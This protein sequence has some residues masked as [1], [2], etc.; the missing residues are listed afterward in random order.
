MRFPL[1]SI[2][3][4][5]VALA[6]FTLPLLGQQTGGTPASPA[7]NQDQPPTPQ[8]KLSPEKQLRNFE[9]AIDEEYTLGAGDEISLDFPGRPELSRKY[10]VGPDGRITLPIA[11]PLTIANLTRAQA[12]KAIVDAL[13]SDYNNLTVTVNVEKYGSN[14]VT[15]LGNV[16][17][18][19]VFYFDSAPTL[20]DAIS[21]GGLQS[22]PSNK[23]GLPDRVM[24]YRGNDQVMEVNLRTLLRSGSA[25]ADVRL[26]RNDI[27][28]VPS[29]AD[30]FVTVLGEVRNPGAIPLTNE[31]TLPSVIAQA[32][33]LGESAGSSPNVTII[34]PSANTSRVIPWKQLMTP[35]GVTEVSLKAGD[36]IVI[37]KSGFGKVAFALQ[38]ISPMT[39]LLSL[40]L[41]VAALH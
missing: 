7:Q 14:R 25:M 16:K 21:R 3:M 39:S 17:T 38:R 23:D 4:A 36:V 27:V 19:G 12:A 32:G 11:G 8:L 20:L 40:G 6:M 5:G 13:S 35:G 10:I 30:Q 37:P 33:G 29:Q 34:E 2:R 15:V 22:T 1:W 41:A 18:P 9:P 28:F 24:I 31:S 26:R